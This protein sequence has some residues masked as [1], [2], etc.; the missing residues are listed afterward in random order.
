MTDNKTGQKIGVW[1]RDWA[2]QLGAKMLEHFPDVTWEVWRPDE[3]A[4]KL[5]KHIFEDGIVAKSFPVKH[6]RLWSGL[7]KHNFIFSPK[8]IEN[9]DLHVKR[10]KHKN[11]L[12][13]LPASRNA[14]AIKFR[15][16]FNGKIAMHYN[17]LLYSKSLLGDFKYNVNPLRLIH[18]NIKARQQKS[19]LMP[20]NS[21][22][23]AHKEFINELEKI[24]SF[25]ITFNTMGAD[26]DFWKISNTKQ[27]AKQKLGL[28]NKGHIFLFSS[29]LVPEYQIDKV[30]NIISELKDKNFYCIFTSHGEKKYTDFLNQVIKKNNINNLVLFTGYVN[31]EQL[32]LLYEA[33]DTFFMTSIIN[34]GPMSTFYAMLMEKQIITTNAGLAAEICREN[35]C[36]LIVSPK[37]YSMWKDA[38][39]YAINGG[40]IKIV[41]R[42][43][44]CSIFDWKTI[45]H[46]W[47]VI[48]INEIKES[49]R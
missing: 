32:K 39:N 3:R 42:N 25:N 48:F 21:L 17:H 12:L 33:A 26:L 2:F 27:E 5:Y 15:E 35:N 36:G 44:A 19:Y 6:I 49:R 41:P 40:S 37:K 13:V 7:K 38:M 20:I 4:D 29:R 47:H 31:E 34:A 22:M 10:N 46:K 9:L 16:H 45:I 30:L 24:Y 14:F 8:M 11:T 23:I 43:L 28:E 18:D 1:R